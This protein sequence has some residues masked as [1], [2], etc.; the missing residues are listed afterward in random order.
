ML[1]NFREKVKNLNAIVVFPSALSLSLINVSF[2]Q[3]VVWHLCAHFLHNLLDLLVVISL[4]K[5][6]EDMFYK[7]Y[8]FLILFWGKYY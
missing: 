3:Y 2:S 6:I 4:A 8:F 5:G 1:V 7:M